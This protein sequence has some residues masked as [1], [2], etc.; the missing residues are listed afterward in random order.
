MKF[1]LWLFSEDKV[2]GVI[3]P[4]GTPFALDFPSIGAAREMFKNAASAEKSL[5]HSFTITSE[6]GASERW[7]RLDGVWR[8]KDDR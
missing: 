7:F 5:A 6:D 1:T 3:A 4:L 8:R 2:R